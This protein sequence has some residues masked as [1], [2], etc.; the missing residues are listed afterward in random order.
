MT[1]AWAL[2]AAALSS[3]YGRGEL[4]PVEVLEAVHQRIAAC[5]PQLNAL[6]RA[7]REA[8]LAQARAAEARWRAGAPRV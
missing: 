6:Y 3:A 1:H 4:S 2:S 5:E 7:D 8:A